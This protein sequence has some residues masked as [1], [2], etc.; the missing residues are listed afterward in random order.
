MENGQRQQYGFIRL[1]RRLGLDRYLWTA[2]D[3][4]QY[5]DEHVHGD[6]DKYFDV[7]A[8]ADIHGDE[9]IDADKHGDEYEY[10]DA[11]GYVD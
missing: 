6:S 11:F 3:G 7:H 2:S 1:A 10:S 8:D 9:Y 5:G 4:N